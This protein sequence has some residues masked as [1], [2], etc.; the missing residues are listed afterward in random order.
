MMIVKV[1]LTFGEVFFVNLDDAFQRQNNRV[2]PST[3]GCIKLLNTTPVSV[4]RVFLIPGKR[5]IVT[6]CR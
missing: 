1:C 6:H 3:V 5:P 4:S 2:T